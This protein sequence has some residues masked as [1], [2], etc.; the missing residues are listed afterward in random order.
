MNILIIALGR[1]KEKYLTDAFKE[2]EK[3]I[4][5]FGRV[6]LEELEPYVVRTEKRQAID[7]SGK[8]L[9]NK[10]CTEKL[11]A[12]YD[13]SKHK[14]QQALYDSVTEYVKKGFDLATKTKN[15]SYAFVMVLFQRMMSSST[16]AI[17]D[18]IEKR[19]N[20]LEAEKNKALT[21]ENMAQKLL[22][23]D[24]DA[25][26]SL[27][28]EEKVNE[29]IQNT[30]AAYETE[31]LELKNLLTEAKHCKANEVDVKFEYL[32]RR[33]DELKKSENNRVER[34]GYY[35]K[36]RTNIWIAA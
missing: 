6:T 5:A 29:Q 9:F 15:T 17:L 10:R 36:I 30:A 4:S 1:L 16:Q 27:D 14:L 20:R 23:E 11:V 22:E 2:Y 3:R 31:L 21:H 25:Q 8:P 19:T 34:S 12:Q 26:L 7:Y 33:L 24:A 13:D 32:L 35:K 18:A 28:F